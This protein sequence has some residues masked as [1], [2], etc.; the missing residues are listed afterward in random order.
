MKELTEYRA[1]L[2]ERLLS[3]ARE[4]R[5]ACLAVKDPSAPLDDGWDVHQIAAHTRDVHDLVY[6][7]RARRTVEEDNPEF[8]NFDGDAYMAEHYDADEPLREL[9]D[10]FVANVETLAGMLKDLPVEAW[11]RESRHVTY[12]GGFTMQTWIE[13]DLAHIEE[14]LNTVRRAE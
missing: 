12:G 6:A 10:G 8:P 7:L 11:S 1:N 2:I 4:F 5:E 9:L 14:H 13:R 3:S